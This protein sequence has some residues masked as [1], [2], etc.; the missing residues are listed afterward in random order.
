MS[1]SLSPVPVPSGRPSSGHPSPVRLCALLAVLLGV[2]PGITQEVRADEAMEDIIHARQG[3]YKLVRHHA[4]VLF[5]MARGDVAYNAEQATAHADNLLALS[6]MDTGSLWPVGS[7]KE[8]M[9]GK[10]RALKK[11]WDTY[12]DIVEKS[13]AWKAAVADMAS[14]A[15]DGVDAIRARVGALGSGCKGCHDNFRA[16]TF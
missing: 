8:D 11:I 1:R 12:P 6:R 7:S 5:D 14:A 13:N 16:R 2:V 4:G 15:G 10:T 9:P 3:Y